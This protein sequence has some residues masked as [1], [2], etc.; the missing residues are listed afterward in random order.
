MTRPSGTG[1]D[2]RSSTRSSARHP[3]DAYA[4]TRPG[5]L[6]RGEQEPC[7]H[8]YPGKSPA[9]REMPHAAERR[10]PRGRDV[11]RQGISVVLKSSRTHESPANTVFP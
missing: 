10:R 8:E 9:R 1:V 4:L 5:S 6:P 7:L 3:A 2:A 11:A